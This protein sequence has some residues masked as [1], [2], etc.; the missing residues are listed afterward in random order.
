MNAGIGPGT[1]QR[2]ALAD[3][4]GIFA[5][6]S[7]CRR[8]DG[9]YQCQKSDDGWKAHHCFND[10]LNAKYGAARTLHQRGKRLSWHE[11]R[12][13]SLGLYVRRRRVFLYLSTYGRNS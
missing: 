8:Q 2:A 4:I 13:V 6:V 5:V 9:R 3:R 7:R 10:G 12:G 11:R 1:S